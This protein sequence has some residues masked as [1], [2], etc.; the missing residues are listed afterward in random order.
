MI[1]Y[2]LSF[3]EGKI[4]VVQK[5]INRIDLLP[6]RFQ[7]VETLYLSSNNIT[8]LDGLQQFTRLKNLSLANNEV[9]KTLFD[10]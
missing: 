2:P 8:T 7:K 5:F 6:Q 4:A 1:E 10:S 3:E 9:L